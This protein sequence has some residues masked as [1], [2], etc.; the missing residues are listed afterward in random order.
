M[1][2]AGAWKHLGLSPPAGAQTM[3]PLLDEG[4]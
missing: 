4:D 2:N 1:L 3:L